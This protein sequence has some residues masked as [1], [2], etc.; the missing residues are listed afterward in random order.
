MIGNRQVLLAQST[1]LLLDEPTAG[2]IESGTM[3][4]LLAY[5]APSIEL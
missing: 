1:V 2:E 4:S 5:H 3:E